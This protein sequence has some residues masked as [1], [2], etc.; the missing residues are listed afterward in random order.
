MFKI[1]IYILL[2]AIATVIIY[3]W[4]L[5]KE[6]NKPKD[7]LDILYSKGEKKVIKAFKYK[8][9]LSRKDIEKELINLKASL[10][11]SKNKLIVQDASHFSKVLVGRLLQKG[12]I[13][14]CSNGYTLKQ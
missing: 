11:Y 1:I 3:T 6:K 2:F 9:C 10:F 8:K 12:M 7:L 5:F 4:G 14:K 13:V